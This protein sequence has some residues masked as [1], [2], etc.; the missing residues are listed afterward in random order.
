[1]VDFVILNIGRYPRASIILG[2]PFLHTIKASIYVASANMHFNINGKKRRFT[3]NPPYSR[4]HSS[5]VNRASLDDVDSI[6]IVKTKFYPEPVIKG[7]QDIS[8]PVKKGDPG[9]PIIIVS[10]GRHTLEA[11]CDLGAAVNIIPMSVYDNALQL[12]PLLKRTCASDL[13]TD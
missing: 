5:Q 10:I 2:R 7:W 6:E 11:A 13:Q 4:R 9:H 12:A 8:W 3:F 1:M